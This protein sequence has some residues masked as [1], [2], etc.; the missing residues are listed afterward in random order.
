[1]LGPYIEKKIVF[2]ILIGIVS[3]LAGVGFYYMVSLVAYIIGYA[4]MSGYTGWTP[5][6][7]IYALEASN[8][9]IILIALPVAALISG[10]IVYRFA[11]E[12][13]GPGVDPT[14]EAY[15]HMRKLHLHLPVVKAV[16]SSIMIGSGGSGGL[17]GPGLQIGGGIGY[18]IATILKLGL[19]Y[20]RILMVAGMAGTLSAVFH[21][22]IGAAL[23]AVEVLYRRDIEVEGIVSS[24]I[25][26]ITA[27]AVST[28]IMGYTW[29]LPRLVYSMVELFT[30]V[31]IMNYIALAFLSAVFAWLY[32]RSFHMVK[33]LV[34]KAGISGF[35]RAVIPAVMVVPVAII[36]YYVPYILGSGTE[37]LSQILVMTRSNNLDI[38]IL[39]LGTAAS[40]LLL[41][42]LKILATSLSMGSGGSGGLFAPAVFIGGT[43][44]LFYGIIMGSTT[45]GIPPYFFAYMGIAS[46]FGAATNTP[47]ATSFMVAEMSGDYY[48]LLPALISSLISN[49]I[50]RYDTLYR[51]QPIRRPPTILVTPKELLNLI[52]KNVLSNIKAW[53]LTIRDK[54][55]LD[56]ITDLEK[57]KEELLRKYGETVIPIIIGKKPYGVLDLRKQAIKQDVPHI[58]YLTCII[59]ALE[60]M[61]KERI[62]YL[63]VAKGDEIIG[64]LTLNE[65]IK[66]LSP[67]IYEHQLRRFSRSRNT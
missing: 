44:G 46:F 48:I 30:P 8:R 61:S 18:S 66:L 20:K 19:R 50:I 17:Q 21:S 37:M 6:L 51:S 39:G 25:S 16:A 5:D 54:I 67:I 64:I 53:E 7:S 58:D 38:N 2:G 57:I 12:A 10:L 3:G 29:L 47:F 13:E 4:M 49:E 14:I 45:S 60:L 28:H 11:P 33:K 22:P 42:L 55:V 15:H 41:V 32:I 43:L 65:I 62:D 9:V 52:D 24:L 27:Y 34:S 23:F 1:M 36:G 31:M 26:S 35:K 63:I 40:L 56:K 59:D